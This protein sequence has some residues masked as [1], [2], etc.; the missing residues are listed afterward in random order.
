MS[1]RHGMLTRRWA[2]GVTAAAM[3]A[4]LAACGGDGGG[5]KSDGAKQPAGSASSVPASQGSPKEGSGPTVPDTSSTLAT[6]NGT[7]G[8]QIVLHSA[9]RDQGGFLTVTGTVKNTTD[10][11]LIAPINWNGE[12]LNVKRTG[13]S[14]AGATLVDKTDKKRYYVLRDTEGF[15]LTTTGISAVKAGETISIFAQ[16]PAPPAT[17]TQ[18]DFQLPLMPVATIEI[19]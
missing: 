1:I 19:S 13:P 18:V 6:I 12:E 4:L 11:T 2:T 14:L 17:T 10:K 16:F 5:G 15:P 8:F 3:A 9:A 7:N